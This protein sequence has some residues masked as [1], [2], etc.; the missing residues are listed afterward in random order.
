MYTD[1]LTIGSI[2]KIKGAK[3]DLMICGR[4]VART[5]S[6]E[7]YDY[8]GCLYP[9]G[10]MDPSSLYFFNRDAIAECIYPGY[11]GPEEQ[12]FKEKVLGNLGELEVV[13]GQVVPKEMK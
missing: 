9:E 4:V 5:G 10:I 12:E 1:L 3:R 13:D 11:D 6:E 7:V 8:V 2:V